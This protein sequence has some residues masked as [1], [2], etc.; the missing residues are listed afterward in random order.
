MSKADYYL[1]QVERI[2][3]SLDREAVEKCVE[4]LRSVREGGGR[5]FVAGSG[6]GAGH[7]S[8][9]VCDFRKLCGFEAYCLTDN[10]SE[11]TARINDEGWN[12]SLAGTLESSRLRQQDGLL[13]FSVG[14]GSEEKQVSVNLVE[15]V[16]LARSRGASVVA[17]V[18]RDGG[19]VAR[20]ADACVIVPT[21]D[22]SLVTPLTESYQAVVWHCF[23][24]H[25]RLQTA[26]AK[27]EGL[28]VEPLEPE[29]P[30]SFW[31]LKSCKVYVD[32][33]DPRQI[34]E[35]SKQEWVKGF[36]TN[37]TL[38]RR[39][40]MTDMRSFANQVLHLT[41]D[42]SLSFEVISDEWDEMEFQALELASWGPQVFVKIPITNTRGESS[43]PLIE[44]LAKARVKM[45]IT[46]MMTPAQV[47]AVLPALASC[48]AA[49][50]SVFAG[51]I[52]DSGRDP[53]LL[54]RQCLELVHGH[55]H[56]ELLWASPRELFNLVQAD[57]IGCHIITV[58][59]DLLAKVPSLGKDLLQFSKETVQ[60]FYNDAQAAGMSLGGAAPTCSV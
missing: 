3:H 6:G 56:L 26:V 48:P 10:V 32:S 25:P 53:V 8:H 31:P 1:R 50:L 17:V 15:A 44:R 13:V 20:H 60:M 16:K 11:L 49:I 7:A 19:Y 22:P 37:P 41:G 43:V 30:V 58:T 21:V 36:T 40:G 29:V 47:E 57:Q 52:A 4:V 46:A 35:W 54:M 24:S 42:R 2:A 51:R 27:W 28:G 9:A 39:A 23:A 14:G 59:T 12:S 55:A 5:L 34:A 18:G 45:N 33:A 38:M